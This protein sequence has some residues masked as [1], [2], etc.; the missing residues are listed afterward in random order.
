MICGRLFY[1]E[2][3][4]DIPLTNRVLSPF[5]KLRA[6]LFPLGFMALA[7]SARAINPSGKTRVVGK[8]FDK[9]RFEADSIFF[10]LLNLP[11][12]ITIASSGYC[13]SGKFKRG[14]T[15]ICFK[16]LFVEFLSYY[17]G[18]EGLS[19]RKKR[20]GVIRFEQRQWFEEQT[21]ARG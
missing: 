7:R 15:W 4:K 12:L 16:T 5:C 13:S 17:C 8:E 21:S 19:F 9:F 2:Q 10:P 20:H 3:Y 6:E 1:C 18:E 11:L 14:K